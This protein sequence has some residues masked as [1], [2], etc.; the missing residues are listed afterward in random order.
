MLRTGD[1]TGTVQFFSGPDL[2]GTAPVFW[3][4][5]A[6]V[7]TLTTS[8]IAD[9]ITAI[10]SGDDNYNDSTRSDS[11]IPPQLPSPPLISSMTVMVSPLTPTTGEPVTLRATINVTDALFPATGT[12][13]FLDGPNLLGTVPL[14]SGQARLSAILSLGSRY[15]IARYSGDGRYPAASSAGYGVL[16][17]RLPSSLTLTSDTPSTVFG[18]AITFRARVAPTQ[19]GGAIAAP[20]GQVQFFAGCL[21]GLF[22][23]MVD[24]TL[25]GTGVLSNGV[26]TVTVT[27]LAVGTTQVVATY[28]SDGNWSSATS[29]AVTQ[30]IAN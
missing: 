26:A 12:V 14:T 17:T 23:M 21:C 16:V 19:A 5:S 6:A 7:A 22:G 13:Q 3:N 2:L 24:R 11:T 27:N 8:P 18:Q 4:R 10:Y 28:L 29:N 20:T 15:I 25:I 9:N 30:T 1:P